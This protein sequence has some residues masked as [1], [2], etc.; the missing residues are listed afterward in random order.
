MNEDPT[1]QA[2]RDIEQC[3]TEQKKFCL[4]EIEAML[5]GHMSGLYCLPGTDHSL[6]RAVLEVRG[7]LEEAM[8]EACSTHKLA[9][10]LKDRREE[11]RQHILNNFC[12]VD[13]KGMYM[14]ASSAVLIGGRK[15]TWTEI[16]SGGK[17]RIVQPDRV[18][19]RENAKERLENAKNLAVQKGIPIPTVLVSLPSA[20]AEMHTD[21]IERFIYFNWTP[22]N[23][24]RTVPFQNAE[25]LVES[26]SDSLGYSACPN[27]DFAVKKDGSPSTTLEV[28]KALSQTIF[29]QGEKY[30]C[31]DVCMVLMWEGREVGSRKDPP[32]E[33]PSTFSEQ[34]QFDFQLFLDPE[35]PKPSFITLFARDTIESFI[36]EVTTG[37]WR[38][39]YTLLRLK[40]EV[41]RNYSDIIDRVDDDFVLRSDVKP[42][43]FGNYI[44]CDNEDAENDVFI[45]AFPSPSGM[46]I[47]MVD[48][49]NRNQS[50]RQFQGIVG[51][52][53]AMQL[54]PMN[55]CWINPTTKAIFGHKRELELEDILREGSEGIQIEQGVGSEFTFSVRQGSS[56]LELASNNRRLSSQTARSNNLGR[57]FDE[58]MEE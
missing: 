39:H 44:L 56:S 40:S 35:N 51:M 49:K 14:N 53:N 54:R 10:G 28:F 30:R 19:A 8:D 17:K 2:Q 48:E 9:D 32:F 24:K 37:E 1:V 15:K 5:T 16:L 38:E 3:E 47:G 34:A 11:K 36:K 45:E 58:L 4:G 42:M 33:K 55:T 41:Y 31:H 7:K 21:T 25:D 29:P 22:W 50:S 46:V 27:P 20:E 13:G 26:D 52:S 18:R 57:S 43:V 6:K 23:D 12:R